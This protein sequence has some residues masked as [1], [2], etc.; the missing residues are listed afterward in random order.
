MCAELSPA[1]QVSKP[2]YAFAISES[3]TSTLI[4]KTKKTR[5]KVK[6]PKP[7][8]QYNCIKCFSNN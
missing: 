3:T 7:N 4:K 1:S 8:C 5:H 6:M 2:E